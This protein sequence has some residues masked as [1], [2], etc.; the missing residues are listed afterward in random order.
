VEAYPDSAL[1]I[2]SFNSVGQRDAARGLGC[3]GLHPNHVK[4]R[5]IDLE[6]TADPDA[7]N[8]C[9]PLLCWPAHLVPPLHVNCHLLLVILVSDSCYLCHSW[10]EIA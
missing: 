6:S 9:H 2:E 7:P 10:F 4:M 5:R 1:A 3:G 8:E